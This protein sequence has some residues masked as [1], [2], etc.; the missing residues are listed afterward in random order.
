MARKTS[1]VSNVLNRVNHMLRTPDSSLRLEG[2][3]P[4]QAFRLGA[5]SLL[6]T[7]LHETGN[8][9]GFNYQSEQFLPAEEQTA[10]QVLK[11]DHDSTRRFYYGGS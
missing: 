7:I 10:D 9:R 5:A 11:P 4:E 6:E 3:T 8:Y 1:T 2:L